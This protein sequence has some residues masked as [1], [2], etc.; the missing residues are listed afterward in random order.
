MFNLI[1]QGIDLTESLAVLP[2]RATRQLL[3]PKNPTF[4]K[5]TRLTEGLVTIPF[6]MARETVDFVDET[7]SGPSE[8]KRQTGEASAGPGFK[9][10][11]V[12]PQVTIVSD[13]PPLSGSQDRRAVLRVTGLLCYT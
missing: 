1:R 4:G 9:N 8:E 7:V 11:F 6:R 13:S 2:L 12:N 5:L 10:L 3:G